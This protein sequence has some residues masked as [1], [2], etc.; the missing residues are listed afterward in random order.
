MV[1]EIFRCNS[2]TVLVV[3]LG[4]ESLSDKSYIGML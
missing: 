1:S 3:F 4:S 2:C